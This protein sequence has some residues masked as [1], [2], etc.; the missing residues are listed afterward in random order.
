MTEIRP[1]VFVGREA[2]IAVCRE[3]LS[4]VIHGRGR[5]LLIDGEPGIG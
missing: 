5:A 1:G 4:Q 2:E 3:V